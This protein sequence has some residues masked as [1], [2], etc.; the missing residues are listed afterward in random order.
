MPQHALCMLA[1]AKAREK[2]IVKETYTIDCIL[3]DVVET[4]Y[5]IIK[6]QNKNAK[7]KTC[8]IDNIAAISLLSRN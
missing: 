5:F 4:G 1:H 3:R 8:C 2:K 6:T 7:A